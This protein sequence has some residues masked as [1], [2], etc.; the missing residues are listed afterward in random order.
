M[1]NPD[2]KEPVSYNKGVARA[3]LE[4]AMTKEQYD[5]AMVGRTRPLGDHAI[6]KHRLNGL[7]SVN[8]AIT[9]ADYSGNVNAI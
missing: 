3:G 9:L 8:M 2:A 1:G 5:A 7:S 6:S 4:V